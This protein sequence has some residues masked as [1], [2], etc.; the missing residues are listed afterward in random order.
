MSTVSTTIDI[1]TACQY[2]CCTGTGCC[3][4]CC[5]CGHTINPHMTVTGATDV[6][7]CWFSC[8]GI[9]F[10][11]DA[12]GITTISFIDFE[13]S[14]TTGN[15]FVQ[16]NCNKDT[17]GDPCSSST[18]GIL[19]QS[20]QMVFTDCVTEQP[21]AIIPD[22][23]ADTFGSCVAAVGRE[24]GTVTTSGP[25]CDASGFL[26]QDFLISFTWGT[27]SVRIT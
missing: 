7:L 16:V 11:Y 10:P 5:I 6:M 2:D 25:V 23:C 27:L 8:Q 17:P 12:P 18:L 1:P 13:C 19:Y 9:T 26:Y 24:I 15:F 4:G 22:S 14:G 3:E 21:I 20:T